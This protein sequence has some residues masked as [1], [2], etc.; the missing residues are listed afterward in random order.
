M[1]WPG[2]QSKVYNSL[3]NA[4]KDTSSGQEDGAQAKTIA[5]VKCTIQSIDILKPPWL[6][7][8][9]KV[10]GTELECN[11]YNANIGTKH[12]VNGS[13]SRNMHRHS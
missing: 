2:I 3:F 6:G 1:R 11:V 12:A 7:I 10:Y 13:A 9:C 4:Q 5:V 8:L